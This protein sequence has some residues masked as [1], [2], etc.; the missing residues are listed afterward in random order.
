[1]IVLAVTVLA[2]GLVGL[3]TAQAMRHLRDASAASGAVRTPATTGPSTPA[4]KQRRTRTPGARAAAHRLGPK[5][6][7]AILARRLDRRLDSPRDA[8]VAA[9]DLTS[10]RRFDYGAMRG[11]IDA[12][13]SKLDILEVLL[14]HHQDA[15]TPVDGADDQLATAMIEHSD[16]A[17]GQTLWDELG[18]APG[19]AAANVRLGLRHTVP[20]PAGYYGMT[21]SG[22]GD[23]VV[24]LQNLVDRHG[25]LTA[26]SRAY[27][28]GLLDD[29]ESD[30]RWGVSA[31]A[32]PSTGYEVKNGW[33]PVDDD[34][35][36]WVVNSDGIV[37]AGGHQLLIAI[38]T[39]HDSDEPHGITLVES[40][41]RAVAAA[42]G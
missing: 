30:Q 35:G 37:T 6:T 34:A 38:M 25:P 17:A 16:N 19:I 21:T 1:L 40:I 4:S 3:R 27:A 26:R 39:R 23:Q 13:V 24:L 14:L 8:S 2:I 12:S 7:L 9:L 20:D 31:A 28:R 32:D 18:Y 5:R 10:G 42:L 29:V 15:H 22:A 41:A 33:M 36:E 11:M